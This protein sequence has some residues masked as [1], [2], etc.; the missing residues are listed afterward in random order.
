[1]GT[2]EA[3]AAGSWEGNL[4]EPGQDSRA[5]I[6]D[7]RAATGGR[8]AVAGSPEE[9]IM[10]GFEGNP[11]RP[12]NRLA[13]SKKGAAGKPEALGDMP[14]DMLEVAR[15]KPGGRAEPWGNRLEPINK[16]LGNQVLASK[17]PSGSR[18]LPLRRAWAI[19]A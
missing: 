10:A 17:E 15:D 5:A 9:G 14:R 11:A 6:E 13:V 12:G 19:R 2:E 3:A 7:R 18:Q 1:V 16:E 4:G 8:L